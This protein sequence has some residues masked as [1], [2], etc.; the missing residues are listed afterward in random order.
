VIKLVES[1]GILLGVAK[2]ESKSRYKA[3]S[4]SNYD[5]TVDVLDENF[6]AHLSYI[7]ALESASISNG[8]ATELY[9]K[10]LE[11]GFGYE[12]AVNDGG[13]LARELFNA[14]MLVMI[15]LQTDVNRVPVDKT[16]V[17]VLANG[18]RASYAALDIAAHVFKYGVL[19][20]SSLTVEDLLDA[21]HG[22]MTKAHLQHDLVRRCKLMY[23]LADHCFQVES[24][25]VQS[26]SQVP[27][28]ILHS[29]EA[30]A[31]RLLVLGL[32]DDAAFGE[33]SDGGVPLWAATQCPEPVLLAKGKS[34]TRPFASLSMPRNF[35]ISIVEGGADLLAENFLKSLVYFRPGDNIVIVAVVEPR[36][37]RG[38]GRENRFEMGTR[39]GWINGSEAPTGPTFPGW[40]DQANEDLVAQMNDLLKKAQLTGKAI[41][42]RTSS[43][44]TTG[45][46][47]ARVAR[48]E[49]IDVI[50]LRKKYPLEMSVEVVQEAPCSVLLI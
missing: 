2:S 31:C 49:G 27:M 25:A 5:R 34:K 29:L 19:T 7:A 20:V 4:P 32:E 3:P 12:A 15:K 13:L 33:G 50:V 6:S 44:T 36:E 1:C 39:F 43:R 21:T 37:P 10:T 9:S 28:H 47:L 45:K 8:I 16:N 14:V 11:P 46:T 42:E 26:Q 35:L 23:K 41:I 40:N 24:V 48:D 17:L 30:N 38:D 18:S 22:D